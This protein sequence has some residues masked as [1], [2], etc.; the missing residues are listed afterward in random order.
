MVSCLLAWP[1]ILVKI[2]MARMREEIRYDLEDM[3]SPFMWSAKSGVE[4]L[5]HTTQPLAITP[6]LVCL[7]RTDWTTVKRNRQRFDDHRG[8]LQIVPFNF[9]RG[10]RFESIR[11]MARLERQITRT[12]TAANSNP[13]KNRL[14]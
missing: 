9:A 10:P 6:H 12:C 5:R 7:G 13:R 3:M 2:N 1:Q 8:D 14:N 4:S 11:D